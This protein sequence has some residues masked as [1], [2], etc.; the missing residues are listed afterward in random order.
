VESRACKGICGGV[1]NGG[2]APPVGCAARRAGAG[3]KARLF[4]L[5]A[6]ARVGGGRHAPFG[7]LLGASPKL[8]QRADLRSSPVATG[9]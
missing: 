3:V 9:H 2:R 4:G 8:E 7:R 5:G 1:G 6:D